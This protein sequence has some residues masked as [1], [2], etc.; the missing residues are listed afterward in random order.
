MGIK[1]LANTKP[2]KTVLGIDASTNSVAFCLYDANGPKKWGEIN[3]VGDNVFERLSDGQRKVQAA[4]R[5]LNPDLVI[6]ESAVFVQNKKTVVLL[7]YSFGAI[8][9]ALMSKGTR[10]E[11]IPPITWQH[12]IGNKPLSKEEKLK[13]Q[14][15]HPDK[16]K[17]WYD[18]KNRETRKQRTM[19]WV[20]TK[21]GIDV[22]NDNVSDAIA[23]A[24][25]G[26]DKFAS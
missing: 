5:K 23:I 17:S 15:A 6:F 16:S 3:F 10:V 22:P 25:V 14:K 13:I 20:K 12:A 24:S 9:A 19:D 26:Y 21:Y 1:K 7:A 2:I 4:L 18:N 8:V 11:E